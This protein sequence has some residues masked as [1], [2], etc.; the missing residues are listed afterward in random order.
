LTHPVIH[1]GLQVIAG[2]ERL[3]AGLSVGAMAVLLCADVIL[4]E[5]AGMSLPWAQKLSLHFMILAG[6][7][8]VSLASSAAG[9]LRPEVGDQILPKRILQ[10]IVFLRELT[11]AVFCGYFA[12][13]ALA[14]VQQSK[15]F[16]DLNVI[17]GV[18][19]W[20]VQA[21]FPATFA[22]MATKHIVFALFPSTRPVRAGVH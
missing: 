17:T 11:T 9:H 5:V 12:H 20:V 18:P 22:L 7:L 14:Y 16:G 4:R 8:G 3:I 15:D 1:R 6:C 13:I 21:I 2:A 10:G 19:L